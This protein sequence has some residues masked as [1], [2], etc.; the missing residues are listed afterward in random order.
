MFQEKLLKQLSTIDAV[1][2]ES[3]VIKFL[4][5]ALEELYDDVYRIDVIDQRD[6]A[7]VDVNLQN[8]YAGE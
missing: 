4:E 2:G 3:G 6:I 8:I 5:A 7:E 1:Y